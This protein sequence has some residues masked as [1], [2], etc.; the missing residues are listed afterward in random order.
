M[1]K[2]GGRLVYAT[3]SILRSENEDQVAK[4]MERHP[5][6]YVLISQERIHPSAYSDGFFHALIEKR[7]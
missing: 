4:F 3:C 1:T 2:P 5:N 7:A 6:E